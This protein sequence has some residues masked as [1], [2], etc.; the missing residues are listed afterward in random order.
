M[1]LASTSAV[2]QLPRVNTIKDKKLQTLAYLM[3]KHSLE[4]QNDKEIRSGCEAEHKTYR[5]PYT[6]SIPVFKFDIK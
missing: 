2:Q 6:T 5:L 1:V 3:G 4:W